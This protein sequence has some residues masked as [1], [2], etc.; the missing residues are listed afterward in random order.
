M[1]EQISKNRGIEPEIV[2]KET[3]QII[4]AMTQFLQDIP[5]E[6]RSWEVTVAFLYLRYQSEYR[7]IHISHTIIVLM[8]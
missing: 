4:E 6:N 5:P 7:I 3:N 2:A 8:V 1:I